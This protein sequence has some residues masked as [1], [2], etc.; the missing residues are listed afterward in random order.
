MSEVLPTATTTRR[1][2]V[3]SRERRVTSV[4]TPH[5]GRYSPL[6]S[7][8]NTSLNLRSGLPN[9]PDDDM[10]ADELLRHVPRSHGPTTHQHQLALLDTH[11]PDLLLTV[12]AQSILQDTHSYYT[13]HKMRWRRSQRPLSD[14]LWLCTSLTADS[15]WKWL[16]F[17]FVLIPFGKVKPPYS[18]S[19]NIKW[20][21][22]VSTKEMSTQSDR[23]FFFKFGKDKVFMKW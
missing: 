14:N 8:R 16:T 18:Q 7:P 12:S 15:Q 6:C 22:K 19:F 17:F 11:F 5:L 21:T 13:L 9:S 23:I 3:V 10:V 20:L 1:R 2:W 4:L